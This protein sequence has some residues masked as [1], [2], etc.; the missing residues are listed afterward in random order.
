MKKTSE[1]WMSSNPPSAYETSRAGHL[2]FLCNTRAR[3]QARACP[4]AAADLHSADTDARS[5][6]MLNRPLRS[7]LQSVLSSSG[8]VCLK[9]EKQ[10]GE[11]KVSQGSARRRRVKRL[12]EL[13]LRPRKPIALWPCEDK[14]ESSES[15]ALLRCAD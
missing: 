6:G 10:G 9:Y 4:Q 14:R 15:S 13:R 7:A 8:Q 3:A 12:Q 1:R 2:A 11:R 5:S